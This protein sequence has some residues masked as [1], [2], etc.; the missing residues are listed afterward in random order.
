[1]L[2]EVA[3]GVGLG[4]G[5]L[6]EVGVGVLV[7]VLVG[8]GVTVGVGVCVGV[9]VGG[10]RSF[11]W[12][13]SFRV[14]LGDVRAA[15]DAPP[16]KAEIRRARPTKKRI[17]VSFR[18]IIVATIRAEESWLATKTRLNLNGGRALTTSILTSSCSCCPK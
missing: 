6:V 10:T 8:V 9:A 14:R 3:V 13:L 1:M 2:V 5:V 17:R 12:A 4:V 7:G 16:A 11:G 15:N 18:L